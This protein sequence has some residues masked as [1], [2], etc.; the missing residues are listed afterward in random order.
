MSCS[1]PARSHVWTKNPILRS[2]IRYSD[3]RFVGK[4]HSHD[5]FKPSKESAAMTG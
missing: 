3:F 1:W 2:F 5:H 4:S